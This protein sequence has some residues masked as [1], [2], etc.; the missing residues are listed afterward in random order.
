[1]TAARL[2]KDSRVLRLC[3][4]LLV[5]IGCW[6]VPV[7]AQTVSSAGLSILDVSFGARSIALAEVMQAMPADRF[8]LYNNP[9]TSAFAEQAVVI[10]G[11]QNMG[12]LNSLGIIGLFPFKFGTFCVGLKGATVDGIEVRPYVVDPDFVVDTTAA[13]A[14]IPALSFA[15]RFGT[16]SVGLAVRAQTVSLGYNP[17]TNDGQ[18]IANTIGVD[19]GAYQDFGNLSM[20]AVVQNLGGKLRFKDL[21][22]VDTLGDTLE[23]E[24]EGT[25]QPIYAAASAR[26]AILDGKLQFLG[27]GGYGARGLVISGGVE[28]S[29]WQILSLRIGYTSERLAGNALNGLTTG[30]GL[31]LANLEINYSFLPNTYFGAGGIH[32]IDIGFHFG[33]SEAQRERLLAE[34]RE[35]A[36]RE[37]LERQKLTS[38]SLYEQGVSQYNMSRYD[39]AISSWDIALIWWPDNADAQQ[40]ISKVSAEKEQMGLNSLVEEAKQAYVS[41]NYVALVVLTEQILAQDSTHS[42]ALFYREEAKKGYTEELISNAPAAVQ[43][44]LRTGIQALADQDYLTAMRSFEKVLDYDP[45][46][47][48]AQDYIRETQA[49]IDRYISRKLEEVNSLLGRNRYS[50]AKDKVRELLELAPRN[51]ELLQK[52][53]EID[54]KL[55]EDVQ[56]RLERAQ[57]TQDPARS[58]KELK[59][60]LQLDPTN[61]EL[62]E[63]LAEVEKAARKSAAD[64][65][66]L[67]LLGVESYS[68]NNYELAISYWQR[69]LDIDPNHANAR[70][71]LSRA[72]TKLAA[73]AGG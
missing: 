9:A 28:F 44:D 7:R 68:E 36:A 47:A 23:V 4:M 3:L 2:L 46:N 59:A 34:A 49:Q 32:G 21:Y 16:F 48:V 14:A 41:K 45:G 70:K 58:E 65:Q 20:G 19:L 71:N 30:F 51:T 17:Y 29:P 11:A 73:L 22:E 31:Q 40:M 67:Y 64:V 69:V 54:R 38:Q 61:K 55:T 37:A 42:L 18:F 6:V 62:Q 5:G 57:E 33:A 53:G 8:S 26:Y 25:P 24:S 10:A 52:L 56:R 27:G 60:A 12:F 1:M 72:Q 66:K 50:E 39:E 35:E 13:V 63:N 43:S 15:R